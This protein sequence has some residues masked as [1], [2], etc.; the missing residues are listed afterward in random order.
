MAQDK[1][2]TEKEN[3]LLHDLHQ[4][5]ISVNSLLLQPQCESSYA[6][7]AFQLTKECFS[8]QQ[9]TNRKKGGVLGQ[10]NMSHCSHFPFQFL[11]TQYW[12]V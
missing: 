4:L 2:K 7:K 10:S 12:D 1:K 9:K 8:C 5:T 6:L 11:E 3:Q